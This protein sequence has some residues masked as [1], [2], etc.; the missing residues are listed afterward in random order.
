MNDLANHRTEREKVANRGAGLQSRATPCLL[1]DLIRFCEIS[2]SI[3]LVVASVKNIAH[4]T[5]FKELFQFS[6]WII[7]IFP[8]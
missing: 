7:E 8:S 6:A 4:F 3:S 1:T 5:N 2:Q